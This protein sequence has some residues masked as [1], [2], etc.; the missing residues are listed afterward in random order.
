[1]NPDELFQ[2]ADQAVK[3]A[4]LLLQSH[5]FDGACNRAYYA[6]FDAA[7]AVLLH[8]RLVLSE[9][10]KTHSGLISAFSLHFVK[11]NIVSHALGKTLNKAEEIRLIADYSGAL[12]GQEQAQW[13]M[14]QAEI[15]V[16]T[17]YTVYKKK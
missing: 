17:L 15:F 3:S 5:D 14:D 8:S 9:K 2:K 16:K 12:V 1:M 10:I 11:T 4:K 7:R 6:M 13:M